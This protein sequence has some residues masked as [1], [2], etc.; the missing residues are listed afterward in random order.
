MGDNK[1]YLGYKKGDLLVYLNKDFDAIEM[2]RQAVIKEVFDDHMIITEL[3]TDTD[4]WIQEG[5]NED[6]I[7]P[8]KVSAAQMLLK[9][10]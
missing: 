2:R 4:L 5:L 10:K 8:C 7:E 3:S 9:G 6:C 1:T